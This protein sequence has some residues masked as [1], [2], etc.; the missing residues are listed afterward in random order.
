MEDNQLE[1]CRMAISTLVNQGFTIEHPRL[2]GM[3]IGKEV[4]SYYLRFSDGKTNNYYLNQGLAKA[5]LI[6]SE[7]ENHF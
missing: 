1:A 7:G 3:K 6:F 5:I 2:P 4:G